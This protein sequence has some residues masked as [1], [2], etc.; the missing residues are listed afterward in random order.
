LLNSTPCTVAALPA[1]WGSRTAAYSKIVWRRAGRDN[2]VELINS[3]KE[4]TMADNDNDNDGTPRRSDS[5]ADA[6]TSPQPGIVAL[7]PVWPCKDP[8]T[9]AFE[10]LALELLALAKDRLNAARLYG[11]DPEGEAYTKQGVALAGAFAKVI[12][13]R[14]RHEQFKRERDERQGRGREKA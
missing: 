4:D 12:G 2:T 5:D 1:R 13:A 9:A 3:A 6:G 8:D 14:D 11:D 10:D 7:R